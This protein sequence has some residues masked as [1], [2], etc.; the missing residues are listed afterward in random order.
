MQLEIPTAFSPNGDGLNDTYGLNPRGV[1]KFELVV[2][3]RLGEILFRTTDPSHR[4]DGSHR[5]QPLETGVY[6]YELKAISTS[7]QSLSRK[8][9]ITLIN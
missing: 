7:R 3:N 1:E 2:Y 9:T 6:A 8:G 5:G 4:W